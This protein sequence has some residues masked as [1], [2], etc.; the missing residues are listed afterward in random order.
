MFTQEYDKWRSLAQFGA[1]F[2][3]VRLRHCA[4]GRPED[5]IRVV[6]ALQ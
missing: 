5:G 4:K 1:V 6:I 2:S 3:W